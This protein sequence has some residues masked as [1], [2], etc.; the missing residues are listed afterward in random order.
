MQGYRYEVKM[1]TPKDAAVLLNQNNM[2]RS[3]SMK[4][5]QLYADEM[6]TGN[7]E[8]NG[9]DI[10]I[11]DDGTLLNGQHRLR[12]VILS[13]C[14]TIFGFKY[15]IPK[16]TFVTMDNGHARTTADYLGI[17]GVHSASMVAAIAKMA[18]QFERGDHLRRA[19]SRREV[20][21]Y[22]ADHPLI[23]DMARLGRAVQDTDLTASPF[24]TVL[25]LASR[26]PRLIPQLTEFARRV[27]DGTMLHKGDPALALRDWA[28]VERRRLR[29]TMPPQT[30][31]MATA[32]A[33]TAYA[34][35]QSLRQIRIVHDQPHRDHTEITG[36]DY[37]RP[38]AQP[39]L[40]EFE[41]ET[42]ATA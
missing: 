22:A 36:F 32:R 28:A 42:R 17:D 41:M 4:R 1:V 2:N 5:V 11:A 13:G 34:Q 30:C 10:L 35:G 18:L 16:H 8:N 40:E 6:R 37:V 27:G 14:A 19:C 39:A 15:G 9:E 33:W 38:R 29:R 25:F 3:I 24:A 31:F 20:L 7:W 12:A 23:G 26:T 21:E